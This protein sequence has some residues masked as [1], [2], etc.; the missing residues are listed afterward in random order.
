MWQDITELFPVVSPDPSSRV[1]TEV[2]TSLDPPSGVFTEVATSLDPPSRVFTEVATAS[3]AVLVLGEPV[4][5]VVKMAAMGAAL[6]PGIQPTHR[7]VA[8]TASKP[9]KQ[10]IL[11]STA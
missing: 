1:Y 6:A 8:E 2:A 9:V 4:L 7:Q 11:M 10:A 5:D 3:G